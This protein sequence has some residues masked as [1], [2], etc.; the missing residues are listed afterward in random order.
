MI[1]FVRAGRKEQVQELTNHMKAISPQVEDGESILIDTLRQVKDI[2]ENKDLLF[3]LLERFLQLHPDDVKSRFALAHSYSQ[4]DQNELSLFH[5]LKIPYRER[6]AGTWNNLGVQFDSCELASKSVDAY[7]K[8]E[9]LGETLAMSNLA[10]KLIG[11]G[12]LKDADEICN[13]AIQ[14]TD[15]HKN[16][17]Y[18][19]Q[20]IKS[21]PE[22]EDQKQ[23][24]VLDK[25]T[26]V[27]E[28]YRDYGRAA[29][30]NQI[31]EHNGRWRSPD[32]ELEITIKEGKFL[33]EGEYE[34]KREGLGLAMTLFAIPG[35]P[36]PPETEKY[37]IQY[38]GQIY[39]CTIKCSVTREE[40]R[41]PSVISTLLTQKREETPALMMASN[42]FSEIRV[43]EKRA[44][45][46]P[47]F[48][49]LTRIG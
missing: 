9:E 3:G 10:Q 8:S 16:V 4:E 25:A 43:Y 22:E 28:F 14:I 40:V 49:K 21:I 39:G 18:A 46:G 23:K 11:A 33:A 48:Y 7:R 42:D 45:K 15:Y 47:L 36:T 17:G 27:S 5:Y 35:V 2:E 20:R 32:C 12:F 31:V 38:S 30:Q 34:V 1:A 6:G 26:P 37:R 44:S 13:R 29:T 41:K 24:V 19:I